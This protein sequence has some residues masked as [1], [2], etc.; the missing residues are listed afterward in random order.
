MF[1]RK[2]LKKNLSKNFGAQI[3]TAQEAASL[4]QP[5]NTL[6]CGGFGVC[7]NPNTLI[8]ALVK[9]GTDGL[10]I[11]ANNPGFD[12]YGVGLL[13]D[14][15]LV[16]RMVGS[17]IGENKEFERQYLNGELELQ[18]TPQGTLAEKIRSGGKGIPAFWT[19]TGA[20]TLI[21]TGGFPL[22]YKLGGGE[23]E[24][25]TEPKES[26]VFPNGIYFNFNFSRPKV[27]PR[28]YYLW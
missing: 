8:K 12:N 17:Y 15:G 20:D 18:I 9:Q 16:K 3:V 10:T 23:E 1:V 14:G 2:L 6:L 25:L 11:V 26:R 7:A 19:K 13:L 21:E 4:V 24:I 28:R 27:Y 22:K 5:G